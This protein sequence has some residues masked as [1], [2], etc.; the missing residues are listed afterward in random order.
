MVHFT[1]H[2]VAHTSSVVNGFNFPSVDSDGDVLGFEKLTRRLMTL[3]PRDVRIVSGHHG[4]ANGY[5]F[6]GTWDQLG[7]YADMMKHAIEIVQQG[8]DEG[9]TTEEMQEAKVLAEYDE[10]GGSYVSA[11]DWIG[12]LAEALTETADEGEDVCLPVYQVWKK[13]GAQAAVK[14]YQELS[15]TQADQYDV[16]EYILMSIGSKLY[17]RELYADAGVFLE[18]CVELYPEAEYGYYTHYLAAKAF[19]KEGQ[20]EQA[21]GH[22]RES[23]RLNSEFARASEFLKELAGD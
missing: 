1:E 5:D 23:V 15:E 11:S 22:C 17:S 9:K 2:R 8:L 12:Y 14:H 6:T 4:Q 19:E 3:L 7:D 18:G 13:S 20:K 16:N 10:Y 21:L